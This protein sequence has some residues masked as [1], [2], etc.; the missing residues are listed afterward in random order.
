M[1]EAKVAKKKIVIGRNEAVLRLNVGVDDV[2]ILMK[3][4]NRASELESITLRLR[5]WQTL[6][7][8][9]QNLKK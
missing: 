8:I 2:H 1:R 4:P 5:E 6:P 7:I 9:L 3:I